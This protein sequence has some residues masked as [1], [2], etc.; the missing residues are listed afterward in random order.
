M[1][2]AFCPA[3][4]AEV[5]VD[6]EGRCFLGHEVPGAGGGRA[7]TAG[8]VEEPEPWVGSVRDDDDGGGAP[9]PTPERPAADEDELGLD[10]DAL[11]RAVAELGLTE[12]D[13]QDS[14]PEPPTAA[15]P[16]TAAE[17]QP[18][19]TDTPQRDLDAAD[20]ELGAEEGREPDAEPGPDRGTPPDRDEERD[21]GEPIDTANFLARP[22][23]ERR[24]RFGR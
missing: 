9:S 18:P 21:D 3:C 16:E 8:G 6:E 23:G 10:L 22:K 12:E 19:A 14:R 20:L 1:A 11:E 2:R 17:A 15:E 13:E 7:T 5:P 24:G 4:A